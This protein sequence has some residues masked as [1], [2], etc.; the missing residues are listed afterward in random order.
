MD[1]RKVALVTGA[2]RGLGLGTATELAKRGF[3]VFM[4]GRNPEKI[5]AAAAQVRAEGGDARAFALDVTR[6]EAAVE[7][8]QK[9]RAE[10]GHLDVLINNA[11]VYLEASRRAEASSVFEASPDTV[12]QTFQINTLGPL[13]MIQVF[14]PLLRESSAGRV[15]NV[16]SGMGQL[17]EMEGSS[18]GYRLSKAALNAV[19][20]ITAAEF[21]G[22]SVKVNSVCPG[23]VKTDMGGSSATREL[24]EGVSS[25]TW[26][27]LIDKDGPTGG[28]FRDGKR[29][30]W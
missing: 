27:A 11:G 8:A 13:Q 20:R 12:L 16:S 23:W 3:V 18:T 19:T 9:I 25:I 4:S 17:S 1:S 7:L 14:A 30:D 28:F 29:L 10:F 15:V 24:A 22:T 5:Q 6:A 21:A 26:A 2:N